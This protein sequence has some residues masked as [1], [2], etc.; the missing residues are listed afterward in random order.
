MYIKILFKIAR[1]LALS[2]LTVLKNYYWIKT[3]EILQ[4]TLKIVYI[5]YWLLWYEP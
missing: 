2:F 4:Y 5:Y 1:K 3:G